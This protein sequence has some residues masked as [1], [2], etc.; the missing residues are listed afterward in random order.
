MRLNSSCT[1]FLWR[2]SVVRMK[3]S[4]EILIRVLLR[5]FASSL[6]RTLN[7]LTMLVG[8]GEEERVGAQQALPP[9]NGVAGDRG[10]GM[11]DVRPRVHIV[12]RG[13]DVELSGHADAI[14][15]IGFRAKM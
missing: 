15:V 3:S 8:A 13:R 1:R 12:N 6:R 10:V 14:F 5:R 11:A 4:F 2:S 7:L 9:R